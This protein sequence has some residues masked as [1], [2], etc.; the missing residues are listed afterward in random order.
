[1]TQIKNWK[2][3]NGFE[4]ILLSIENLELKTFE[5]ESKITYKIT[6]PLNMFEKYAIRLIQRSEEV[7]SSLNMNIVQI[8]KLLHLDEKLISEN[9]E[10]LAA[11]GMLNGVQSDIITINSD[12]NAEYLQHENKFKKESMHKIYHVTK[13]EYDSLNKTIQ[14]IFEKDSQNKDKKFS[15][16]DILE[17]EESVKYAY[18]LNYSDNKFLTY[19]SDGINS[20]NDIKFLDEE[21]MIP[22]NK[23]QN[24]PLNVLC[25]YDEFLPLLKNM[26]TNNKDHV[27]ILSSK[28]IEK[29]S[30]AVLPKKNIEDI[31]I[32]SN[33]DEK[34][35]RIFNTFQKD[36]VWIGSKLYQRDG[37]FIVQK[38]DNDFKA[39]VKEMLRGYFI[40]QIK[41][42]FPEYDTHK[43]AEIDQKIK[44]LE[45]KINQGKT[46]KEINLEVQKLNTAK[47]KLYGIEGN[48]AKKR[49]ELR[50]KIDKLEKE[51]N[52]QAL[53]KYP[54]YLE[55]RDKILAYK[56][57]VDNIMNETKEN[58]MLTKKMNVLKDERATL[59]P[60]GIKEKIAPLEKEF[61][62]LVRLKI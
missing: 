41:N 57:Q 33:S 52:Q 31:Y 34:H 61:K 10:N 58:D 15:T 14:N 26:L 49:S 12:E 4:H 62:N 48:N 6:V 55:N 40:M 23:S 46:K 47:N 45:S 42:I 38:D 20:Q 7:H 44:V 39:E 60:A 36:F 28:E 19:S 22:D 35:E 8:A 2:K 30:L 9:L 53:A 21:E 51:N 3:R 16:V 5:I 37:V 54:V 56:E 50:K 43:I 24:I 29:D 11:I 25:H 59:L 32:L 13:N 18:L 17:E 1:M 27:V